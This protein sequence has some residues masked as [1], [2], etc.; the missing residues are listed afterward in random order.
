MSLEN[1][2][3]HQPGE[4]ESGHPRRDTLATP[5]GSSGSAKVV[6]RADQQIWA[7]DG[8]IPRPVVF[9]R[10]DLDFENA[11]DIDKIEAMLAWA[12]Q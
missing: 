9:K 8:A 11:I 5:A 10:H 7:D 3:G 4:L 12:D 2:F 1:S 6:S